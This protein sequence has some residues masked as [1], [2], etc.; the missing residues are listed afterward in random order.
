LRSCSVGVRD[1]GKALSCHKVVL[2]QKLKNQVDG[3]KRGF[4][5]TAYASLRQPFMAAL[6]LYSTFLQALSF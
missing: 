3:K 4:N 2:G 1:I 5:R 6:A